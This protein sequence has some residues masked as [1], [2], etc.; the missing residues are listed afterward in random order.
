MGKANG[1]QLFIN[2]DQAESEIHYDRLQRSIYPINF[3]KTKTQKPL[4]LGKSYRAFTGEY[5]IF[6]GF[7]DDFYLF[8][9]EISEAEVAELAEKSSIQKLIE[10]YE[11]EPIDQIKE[12]LFATWKARERHELKKRD[13]SIAK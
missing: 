1:I 12:S 5:G 4:R 8:S 13:F 11:K 3:D 6:E 7:M 9:R 10:E 2:G